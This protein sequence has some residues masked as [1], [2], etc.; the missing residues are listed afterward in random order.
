VILSCAALAN[1][2]FHETGERR[3]YVDGWVDTLVIKLTIDEDLAFRNIACQVGDRVRNIV[4]RHSQNGNLS[5]GAVSTFDTT[6]TLID[7]RQIS[8]HI[9]RVTTSTRDFFS[10]S[11]DLTQGIAV[12]GKIGKNDEDVLLKLVGVVFGGGEGK[13]R[14]NDTL[15]T[16]RV[17]ATESMSASDGTYVGSLAKFKNRVTRSI[18]PFSSKSLVKKRLVSKLT[19]IAPNTMEKFSSCPSCTSFVGFPT[20]PACRQ[21]WAAIS[22]CGRPEAEKMGIFWPRAMEFMVSMAEIPVEIIS[23]GYTWTR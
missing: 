3:Q 6:C 22:L 1:G 9:T 4:V 15:D 19:P 20:K 12:G 5:N 18:L 10:G 11:G 8:V 2:R 17:L 7:G 16:R 13:T 14:G 21:I 23:S